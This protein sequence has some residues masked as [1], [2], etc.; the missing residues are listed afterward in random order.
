MNFAQ[1]STEISVRI[2]PKRVGKARPEVEKTNC[3]LV[4]VR[5]ILETVTKLFGA[6]KTQARRFLDG[7]RSGSHTRVGRR[8]TAYSLTVGQAAWL[9]DSAIDSEA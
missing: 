1:D 3:E 9:E 8:R 2:G 7:R 4:K 6:E 5:A